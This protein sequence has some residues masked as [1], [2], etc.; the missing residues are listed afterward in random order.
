MAS[1]DYQAQKERSRE[2]SERVS[3]EGRDIG[4]LPAVVDAAR[5][6]A[7]RTDF[8]TF[9]EVYHPESF[10]LAWSDDHLRVI[11]KIED[12]VLRGGQ[13]AIA[14]PRG[15][16]KSTMCEAAAEWALVCGHRRYVVLVGADQA[17]ACG[18]LESITSDLEHN[19]QLLGD[20]PE[21]L[22]PIQALEGIHQRARGQ[23]FRGKPTLISWTKTKV[24]LP[25]IPGSPAS[26]SVLEVAG[27]TGRI[28]G[29]KHKLVD[30]KVIRPDLVIVDDPQTEESAWSPS[31]CAHRERIV[32][33]AVLGLAGPGTTISAL[34]PCTVIAPDDM[35]DRV[36]DRDKHPE[37]QGERTKLVY[38]WPTRED[39]WDEYAQIYRDAQRGGG[40]VGK[41]T[42]FYRSHRADMDKGAR[43][44]WPARFAANEL[45]ALQHAVNLR[46]RDAISFE[47]EY[48]NEPIR[49]DAGSD[50]VQLDADAIAGRVNKSPRGTV[51]DE[52]S[53]VTA[54]VDV[55][56]RALFWVVM[57][58][59]SNLKGWIVDYGTEPEQAT[60][61]FT[62][63]QMRRTLA[64]SKPGASEAEQLWA[65]LE[66]F[67]ERVVGREWPREGGGSARVDLALVDAN[68]AESTPTVYAWAKQTD[69]SA[70]VMPSHGVYIGAKGKTM[71]ERK[72]G[73]G[74]RLGDGWMVA[75][76]RGKKYARH[77]L[78]DTN[79]W[80]SVLA[81]ALSADPGAAHA[82]TIYGRNASEH[83]LLGEHLAS[84][85][86]V[87]VTA[88]DRAVVEWQPPPPGRDNHW[89]DAA[90]LAAAAAGV[91]GA[92]LIESTRARPRRRYKLSELQGR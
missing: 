87:K 53:L 55:Q 40:D 85:R 51:P 26:G 52:A 65:G 49:P 4:D 60:R 72:G 48:Q 19:E 37:W 27:L 67:A 46:L 78:I 42:E 2:R 73:R 66:R 3:R 69:H 12:V 29:M 70:A 8:R 22:A 90:V 76:K 50:L 43:V 84:E 82:V 36:L 21:V 92:A 79:R 81:S 14:M 71:D 63:R 41:A 6:A 17:H 30:G 20:F 54:G 16:G 47:S 39:L 35:A 10:R 13:F 15:S 28:R 91:R 75:Q 68:W 77:A 74:D 62:L 1:A 31:Q 45:S 57:A 89:L 5:R 56:G 38:A 61:Y 86:G 34:M 80:K 64:T 7:A 23:L 44:A 58:W 25:T 83:R 18:M 24:V 32:C 88:H 59:T 9:C 11:A 33:G